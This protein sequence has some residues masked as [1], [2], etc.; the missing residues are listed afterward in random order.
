MIMMFHNMSEQEEQIDE[1][2]FSMKKQ[3]PIPTSALH[4]S[5]HPYC[6]SCDKS[7]GSCCFTN[8]NAR[9]RLQHIFDL[10]HCE[11]TFVPLLSVLQ[12][13]YA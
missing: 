8:N 3:S 13:D 7:N 4:P 5:R 10:T 1:K 12:A 2:K 9:V 11:A 6:C